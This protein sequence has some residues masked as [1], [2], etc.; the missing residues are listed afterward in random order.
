M[1]INKLLQQIRTHSLLAPGDKVIVA[2]SGGPDSV[3][4]AHA[5][6][7]LQEQLGI[8]LHVAHLNHGIRGRE[9]DEDAEFVRRL[10][11]SLDLPVTIETADVPAVKK[12]LK[13]SVEEAAR[14]VRYEF[15]ERIGNAT[16]AQRIAIAHTADDQ[17]ETVLMNLIRGAGPDGLAGIPPV[18][19]KYIRPL[20]GVTRAEVMLYC[21]ENHLETRTDSTNLRDEYR[22]NRVRL[23]LIPL[24]E[25]GYNP[26]VKDALVATSEIMREESEYMADKAAEILETVADW[27][28]DDDTVFRVDALL[29]LPLALRRRCLR[30]AIEAAKG[31]LKDV[32]FKQV[33]RVLTRLN[34]GKSFA[35]TLPSGVVYAKMQDN[36]LRVFRADSEPEACRFE[37][38]LIV[39]G[40]TEVVELK[41][42]FEAEE[43]PRGSHYL[44]PSKSL[45][46]VIDR[47]SVE[48]PL[49]ARNWRPGDRIQPLGMQDEKKL[50][51]LFVDAKIPRRRR[52]EIPVIADTEKIIW[53]AG[54]ALSD[55]VKVTER[56]KRA[57]R[58][59]CCTWSK[60][61]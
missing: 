16:A 27:S 10:A 30:M 18:R 47:D 57:L 31:D 38:E 24:L 14:K 61:Q 6:R 11:D 58:L 13:I 35:L 48:G 34:G 28:R 9:A 3:A 17:A 5:L 8:S 55:A 20:L 36:S 2:V 39:P 45:D 22:R 33:E 44:R 25:S 7:D 46:V 26:G 23:E 54:L 42:V 40:V 19:G 4:L 60:S 52:A 12:L 29:A 37:C 56:T 32:A 59:A 51:D 15:L 53:V 43:L 1:L 49:V 21:E 50:Q 41:I